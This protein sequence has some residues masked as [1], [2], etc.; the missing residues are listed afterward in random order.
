[1]EITRMLDAALRK[2]GAVWVSPK[3]YPARLVW[4]VW[5]DG[6]LWV[7]VGQ[8]EQQV[9]GLADA[10]TCTV[11]LRSPSTHSHLADVPVVAHLVQPDEATTAALEA[12]RLNAPP[13]WT[14]VYRLDPA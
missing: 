13:R 9:P 11:T 2:A 12:A 8:E 4:T 6:S 1:V 5:R 3:G 14:E 10:V 7:A